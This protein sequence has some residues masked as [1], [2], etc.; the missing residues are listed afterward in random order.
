MLRRKLRAPVVS[1]FRSNALAPG[2]EAHMRLSSHLPKA[3]L[4]HH[5]RQILKMLMLRTF[6]CHRFGPLMGWLLETSLYHG[7]S[8][9]RSW[10]RPVFTILFLCHPSIQW[11][12]YDMIIQLLFFHFNGTWEN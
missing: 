3:H 7:L 4:C 6:C 11:A 5:I 8:Y 9:L 1:A 12:R 10:R 2:S